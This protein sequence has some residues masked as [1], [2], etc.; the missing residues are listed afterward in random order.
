MANAQTAPLSRRWSENDPLRGLWRLLTSVRFALGLITFLAAGALIGIVIPQLPIE[1]RDNPVAVDAWL[2]FQAERFG[3]ATEAMYRAGLFTVFRSVWFLSALAVLV[4]SVCVCTANR[5]PPIW[6]NVF[7]PQTRVPD[8]YF[9][10]GQPVTSVAAPDVE[11]LSDA[12]RRRHYRVAT[13]QEAAA[14]YLFADRYPWAQF[15]TFVS[16]LALILFLAGGLVTVLTARE[17]QVLAAEGETGTAIFAPGDRDHMQLY[18]EDAVGRF[19]ETGFPL[20]FRSH[21][22]VY[23]DGVEVARGVT[24]VNDPLEYGGYRFH[25]S[26]YFPDGAAL[27]VR[28]LATGRVV[29]DEVLALTS[30]AA[31]PRVVLRDAGGTVLLDDVIVPTDFIEQAAGTRV[32]VPALGREFWIGARPGNEREGWQLIVFETANPLGARGVLS[33][34]ERHDIGG[35]SISFVGMTSVPSTVARGV[36]G[37]IPEAAAELSEGPSGPLLT[38]GPIAGRALALSPGEPVAIGDYEYTFGGK[39]EFAGI[40]VRRDPGSTLIWVATGLFLLGLALTFYTPRRRLWGK[41]AA[42]QAAFRGLGGRAMAIDKEIRQAAES[43]AGH[44]A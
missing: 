19:D 29:Y 17:Q 42:G 30:E 26:A 25:Q 11:T 16:H 34:G 1:M 6:R 44:S 31:T 2:A 35:A 14:T 9:E 41:I 24:T 20:D 21:L 32:F 39:R 37:A 4:G 3:F 23:Q 43:A 33:E 15:A 40:T 27:R 12:L 7:Q 36:P 22:V 18:V 13:T 5:L 10:R 28:E 38:L 8:D